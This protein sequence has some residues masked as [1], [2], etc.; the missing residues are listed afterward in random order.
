MSISPEDGSVKAGV[1][2][3][4]HVWQ[5]E[6]YGTEV[7]SAAE[8]H[9]Q[10]RSQFTLWLGCNLTI[11]D[12]ALGFLPISLGMSWGWAIVSVLVGNLLG[13][14]VLAAC[15]AMGPTYGVPQLIIGRYTF[16]RIGGYLPAFFNYVSTI[17]WFAVNNILGSF[18]L[19]VLFP[20][21]AFWQGALILVVIQGLLAVYGHNLIHTYERVMSVV[22][23][24][25]FAIVTVIAITH[26]AK[27]GAYHPHTTS[28]WVMFLVM[29]AAAFS[30]IGSWG[31]YASDYSRYLRANTSRS[32]IWLFT[33]LGSFI[34]SVWLELVGLAVGVLA[35]GQ[36]AAQAGNPIAELH[37]VMGGFGAIA[38]V[39]IILGGTAA[40]AL[41]LYSNSLTAGALD[42]RLPRWLLAVIASVIGLVLS[43][44]GSGHFESNYESFLLMLGYWMMPWVAVLFSDF[45]VLKSQRNA[46]QAGSRSRG[47]H[48]EQAVRWAGVVSFLVGFIVSIP[49]MSSSLY[50]GFL[51]KAMH[52]ADLTFYVGFVVAAL[53]YLAI[54]GLGRRSAA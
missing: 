1:H 4:D 24:I 13:A 29:V 48:A 47:G 14:S 30:Y 34:A 22:L 41:N 11:A 51:A 32:R 31:P 37:S 49:F 36:A 42:I 21:L 26:H 23:G 12:F 10:P 27:L 20:Q 7:V 33:F 52:G 8:R 54:R 3:G 50:T 16:G 43:L 38:V 39:A 19:Q 9:G 45:Y 35:V 18:G 17:G 40:D 5:V 2:Y 15:S 25:L 28:P 53:C 6:P 44:A 46:G